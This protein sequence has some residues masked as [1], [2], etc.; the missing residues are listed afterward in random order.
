MT[1]DKTDKISIKLLQEAGYFV[2]DCKCWAIL[3]AGTRRRAKI[4]FLKA[5]SNESQIHSPEG[6]LF[7]NWLGMTTG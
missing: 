3:S 1:K 2:N 6:G 7:H 5:A 4:R